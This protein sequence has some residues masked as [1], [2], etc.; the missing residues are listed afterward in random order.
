[1]AGIDFQAIL[2]GMSAGIRAMIPYG[3]FMRFCLYTIKFNSIYFFRLS[4]LS[5]STILLI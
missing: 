4:I 1:M 3:L 2:D 5:R